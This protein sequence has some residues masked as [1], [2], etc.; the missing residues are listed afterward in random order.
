MGTCSTG[1]RAGSAGSGN[2][3]SKPMSI[4]QMIAQ[5]MTPEQIREYRQN[6]GLYTPYV[7][8]IDGVRGV[9]SDTWENVSKASKNVVFESGSALL[10][11]DSGTAR[12]KG[13]KKDKFAILNAVNT[14]VVHLS[15]VSETPSKREVAKINKQLKQ[16][17]DM[18]FDTPS[19][20]ANRSGETIVFVKRL[21]FTK[22]F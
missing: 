16:I 18:G 15:G 10:T 14:A 2:T 13:D 22:N 4:K 1:S 7:R 9:A 5:G 17:R 11:N 8:K 12:V 6:Q 3:E 20:A 19:I 21:R